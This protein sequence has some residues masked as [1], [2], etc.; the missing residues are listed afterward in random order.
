MNTDLKTLLA[1]QA[2]EIQIAETREKVQALTRRFSRVDEEIA[3]AD[4]ELE[5]AKAALSEMRKSYRAMESDV[6]AAEARLQKS[7]TALRSV[8]NNREYQSLLKEIEDQKGKIAAMED[9]M[10]EYLENIDKSEAQLEVKEKAF[11]K[12][13]HQCEEEKERTLLE[14]EET[15]KQLERMRQDRREVGGKIHPDLAKKYRLIKERVGPMVVVAA[16]KAVCQGCYMNIPPQMYNELQQKDDIAYCPHCQ[17]MLYWKKE[18]ETP[19]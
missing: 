16:Q 4:K 1:F 15:E 8:K 14:K 7:E 9:G 5:E 2:L 13:K 19:S 18:Q 11:Q 10:L 12:F 17:R 6:Q 3:A